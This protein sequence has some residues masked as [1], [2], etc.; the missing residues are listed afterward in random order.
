MS[1][2]F[3]PHKPLQGSL[4]DVRRELQP[5][6]A[7]TEGHRDGGEDM[8]PGSGWVNEAQL[9]EKVNEQ[10]PQLYDASRMQQTGRR[11]AHK[12]LLAAFWKVSLQQTHVN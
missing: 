6:W 8:A 10:S 4:G 11:F 2:P 5:L 12:C 9:C 3:S 1:E 7:L